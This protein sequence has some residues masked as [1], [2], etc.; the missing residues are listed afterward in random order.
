VVYAKINVDAATSKNSSTTAV[1]AT[2]ARDVGART[3]LGSINICV[4]RDNKSG[5]Y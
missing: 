2:L 5:D 4:E 3:V 1:V